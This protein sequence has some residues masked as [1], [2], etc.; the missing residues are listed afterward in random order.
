MGSPL[1]LALS[2][3]SRCSSP[4][5]ACYILVRL[6]SSFSLPVSIT[7][8]KT[9]KTKHCTTKGNLLKTSPGIY[10]WD[11]P[12][13]PLCLH[14][15]VALNEQHEKK[16]RRTVSICTFENSPSIVP[17][18]SSGTFAYVTTTT[19]A[20]AAAA[21]TTAAAA[22]AMLADAAKQTFELSPHL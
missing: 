19:A 21:A 8:I 10:L 14:F 12:W 18:S 7:V 5:V 2:H 6:F 3:H 16:L 13:Y 17:G 1:S 22:A 9:I 15:N 4:C 20:A 11:L